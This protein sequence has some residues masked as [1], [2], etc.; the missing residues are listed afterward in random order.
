MSLAFG[1]ASKPNRSALKYSL[2]MNACEP[3]NDLKSFPFLVYS[4]DI[5]VL[6]ADNP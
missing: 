3:P 2:V 1:E 4:I 6:G 5:T